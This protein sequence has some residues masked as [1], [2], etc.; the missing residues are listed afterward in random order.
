[1]T[2]QL[3][4]LVS[5][6]LL[7]GAT[8]AFAQSARIQENAIR[9]G[10]PLGQDDR[11]QMGAWTPVIVDIEANRTFVGTLR[12]GTADGDGAWTWFAPRDVRFLDV[13]KERQKTFLSYIKTGSVGGE[14]R[15]QL[16]RKDGTQEH[17]AEY[18]PYQRN[19]TGLDPALKLILCI[20]QPK[21][22]A[23][24]QPRSHTDANWRIAVQTEVPKL[25]EFGF[26]YEGVDVIILPTGDENWPIIRELMGDDSRRKALIQWVQRG[27]HLIVSVATKHS[28]VANENTFPLERLLPATIDASATSSI[29]QLQSIERLVQSKVNTQTGRFTANPGAVVPAGDKRP[30]IELA[31]L[32]LR[33]NAWFRAS[34]Q[35]PIIP[36]IVEAPYGL[37]RVTLIAFDTDQG[38]FTKW[39]GAPHFWTAL[40]DLGKSENQ[41]FGG[42]MARPEG[43]EDL[44]VRLCDE[45]EQFGEVP[46]IRFGWVAAFILAYIL[47]VGPLD[48][49]FLKKVVKRMELTWIT[50]PAVVLVVSVGAYIVANRVKGSELRI[51]KVDL[52]D[53]DLH[54]Q[55][56]QGTTWFSIFSPK[57]QH[58]DVGLEALPMGKPKD[59]AAPTP[60]EGL[61]LSWM[62]RPDSGMRSFR[63]G[64]SGG[65]FQRSY[66]FEDDAR[67]LKGLP[68]QV[69]SV[70]VMT[71]RWQTPIESAAA[72]VVSNLSPIPLSLKGTLTSQLP[73]RLRNCKLFYRDRAWDLG[74]LEPG[75]PIDLE[76]FA[77]RSASRERVISDTISDTRWPPDQKAL[78]HLF[79]MMFGDALPA[80]QRGAGTDYLKYLDQTWRLVGT[81]SEAVLVGALAPESGSAVQVNNSRAAGCRLNP[82]EPPLSGT[83]RQYTMVRVFLPVE[84]RND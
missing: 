51:N 13:E 14:I 67:L 34:E 30:V 53:F 69:W 46:V 33:P 80:G 32:S 4:A 18:Q 58:Y 36:V 56:M 78:K 16:I 73:W 45:L 48:Y 43:N 5:G 71:G 59:A 11:Y 37:G 31:K 8:P 68:V 44:A 24:Q 54:T 28:F 19:S 62:G 57:F 1:M 21:G 75:K 35:N 26:G 66:D 70:K 64:Q 72:P 3:L 22:F 65:L 7:I 81:S 82:F 76:Q 84:D 6:V 61:V 23:H 42:F 15:V 29:E 2:R 52:L 10:F 74:D 83:M 55:Q 17:A 77:D 47:I 39:D 50:F 40:L 20:G 49:F 9:V 41:A 25:P 38:P 63:R 12:V 60:A 79:Q 27:G